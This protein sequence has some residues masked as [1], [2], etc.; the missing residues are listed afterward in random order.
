MKIEYWMTSSPIHD[1]DLSLR[2]R[3]FWFDSLMA[4]L[5]SNAPGASAGAFLWT[6]GRQITKS[7]SEEGRWRLLTMLPYI[8]TCIETECTKIRRKFAREW[9]KNRIWYLHA[10]VP[11]AISQWLM[12]WVVR[13]QPNAFSLAFLAV[14]RLS[15]R[16][17]WCLCSAGIVGHQNA[18]VPSLC[19]YSLLIL[20]EQRHCRCCY[21]NRETQH[22]ILPPFHS[23]CC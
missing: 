20:I 17:H 19:R 2:A 16:S 22:Q 1:S 12:L 9:Q 14:L 18:P 23:Y 8:L 5:P 4:F 13:L 7:K 11:L 15:R 6:F 21:R 3:S 10:P